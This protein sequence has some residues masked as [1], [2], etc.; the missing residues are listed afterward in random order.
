ME[1][2]DSMN[3]IQYFI[4]MNDAMKIIEGPEYDL[5]GIIQPYY[6]EFSQQF[7][8]EEFNGAYY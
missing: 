8:Q 5:H 7:I 6:G 2:Y 4:Q 1:M 3:I